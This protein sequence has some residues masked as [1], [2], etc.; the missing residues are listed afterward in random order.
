MEE[1]TKDS[2][3]SDEERFR[4]LVEHVS[5]WIWEVDENGIYTYA[6]PRIKDIL[7]YEP[8]EVLGKTPFDLMEPEEGKRIAPIFEYHVANKLPIKSLEN[9]NLHRD[10]H[11]V[12]LETSGSPIINAEGKCIGYRGVDRDITERKEMERVIYY[13]AHYDLLTNL[14]NRRYL[15][16]KISKMIDPPSKANRFALLFIDLDNFKEINDTL[17]HEMGDQLLTMLA[18]Q[19]KKCVRETDFVSRYGGDEFVLILENMQAEADIKEMAG[20]ILAA[21]Q[22][23]Y[24]FEGTYLKITGSIGI[25]IFP[26]DGIDFDTLIKKADHA[27]YR[28]KRSGKNNFSRAEN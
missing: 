7:G 2:L 5:D 1:N 9:I 14:P 20:R 24:C 17:G 4:A 16:K 3:H 6:S 25:S 13:Q 10:G 26:D 8:S 19:L 18:N 15:H 11:E 21:F 12:I 22:E 23:P 27:M 28:I